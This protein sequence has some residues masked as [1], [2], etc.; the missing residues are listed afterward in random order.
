MKLENFLHGNNGS[1]L[2]GWASSVDVIDQIAKFNPAVNPQNSIIKNIELL[3]GSRFIGMEFEI[4]GV[5]M[6]NPRTPASKLA[7]ISADAEMHKYWFMTND[8]SLRN[9]GKEFVT[10][11]GLDIK[12]VPNALD[13]LEN[14][15]YWVYDPKMASISSRC[16]V[17]VH[18]NVW[19]FTLEDLR[20]SV[21]AYMFVERL[22]YL[23]SGD[24]FNNIFCVPCYN[25]ARTQW[26]PLFNTYHTSHK[27]QWESLAG[28]FQKYAGFNLRPIFE[29]GTIELRHHK[30]T[31][32]PREIN[33][34]VN[35]IHELFTNSRKYTWRTWREVA[36]EY[37]DANELGK[38]VSAISP[39]LFEKTKHF[40]LNMILEPHIK[41]ALWAS[42]KNDDIPALDDSDGPKSVKKK[43]KPSFADVA[44]EELGSVF[45]PTGNT[46]QV[47]FETQAPNNWNIYNPVLADAINWGSPPITI[48]NTSGT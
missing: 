15:L 19:D 43:S 10:Y 5:L 38:L 48:T 44:L 6:S 33:D 42:A 36:K 21:L 41:F 9:A 22:M 31:V 25:M 40:N 16:S 1:G 20:S 24:R 18:Y 37:W 34:W 2:H 8:G 4:E 11:K 45:L 26:S 47:N 27:L 39:L 28:L 7:Q 29:Y 3:T 13:A 30:G 17:H 46:Q 35:I 32:H 12:H 23:I 14:A